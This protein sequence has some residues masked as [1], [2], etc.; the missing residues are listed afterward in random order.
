MLDG[1]NRQPPRA[2]TP[3]ALGEALATLVS[4]EE[5]AN[6]MGRTGYDHVAQNFSL[7]AFGCDALDVLAAGTLME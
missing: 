3:Y 1:K 6:T 7:E 5:L 2:P 4:N